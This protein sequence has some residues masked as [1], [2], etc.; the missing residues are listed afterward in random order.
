MQRRI[1]HQ[2]KL[3]P[4]ALALTVAIATA[5]NQAAHSDPVQTPLASPV[6][7]SGS[8]GGSQSSQCGYINPT[9]SQVLVV[10]QTAPLRFKVQSQ[11]QPTLWIKGPVDRCVMADSFANGT[12][13]VPG[14]WEKG[15][16]SIFVGTVQQVGSQPFTLSITQEN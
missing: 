14:V 3:I 15:T 8:A 16:Y 9:P 1:A 4:T 5:A 10:N 2:L 7:V 12:V 6:T 13:E 11:G